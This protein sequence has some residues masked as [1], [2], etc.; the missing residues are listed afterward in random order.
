VTHKSK[1]IRFRGPDPFTMQH[2]VSMREWDA[3]VALAL[4]GKQTV[5]AEQ[6]GI[7]VQT[8]KNLIQTAKHRQQ[9][10][11]L[12][13]LYTSIGWLIV[14]EGNDQP[15]G[16]APDSMTFHGHYFVHVAACPCPR[17]QD[18]VARLAAQPPID[19]H[20]HDD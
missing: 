8:F 12:F 3:L 14:P 15:E 17:I 5:A 16:D 1:G 7:S 2:G 10:D 13:D 9:A 4:T 19:W 20:S 6:L 18:E 11:H